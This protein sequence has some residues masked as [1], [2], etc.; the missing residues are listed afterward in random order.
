MSQLV[1]MWCCCGSATCCELWDCVTVC[2]QYEITASWREV[3]TWPSGQTTIPTEVR[4]TY[5]TGGS[6]SEYGT[7]CEGAEASYGYRWSEVLMDVE[8]IRR[9][10]IGKDVGTT[11]CLEGTDDWQEN[12]DVYPSY[13]LPCAGC[14]DAGYKVKQPDA[15]FWQVHETYTYTV[16]H[17]FTSSVG[18]YAC[19]DSGTT[20]FTTPV[21]SAAPALMTCTDDCGGCPRLAFVFQP[22]EASESTVLS[23]GNVNYLRGACWADPEDSDAPLSYTVLPFAIYSSCVCPGDANWKFGLIGCGFIDQHWSYGI[24]QAGGFGVV[25]SGAFGWGACGPFIGTATR[26]DLSYQLSWECVRLEP[27]DPG[28][29]YTYEAID[30]PWYATIEFQWDVSVQCV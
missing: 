21:D 22:E 10:F 29:V 1:P 6:R 30:I 12:A 5:T 15:T 7:K 13:L 18:S 28:E 11:W 3:W 23:D 9:V 8:W 2:D 19:N 17:L 4:Y 20:G 27:C 14:D 16:T 25:E 24:G 26:T